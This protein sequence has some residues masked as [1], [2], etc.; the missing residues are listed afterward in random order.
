MAEKVIFYVLI[1]IIAATA[2]IGICFII[3]NRN[4]ENIIYNNEMPII[5][6]ILS[7][8][9][10]GF[11]LVRNYIPPF[12]LLL[13]AVICCAL[14]NTW[15]VFY[16]TV[17]SDSFFE[18]TVFVFR[19]RYG[20]EEIS[21]CSYRYV[22]G[23]NGGPVYT[24]NLADGKKITFGSVKNINNFFIAVSEKY[25]EIHNG[26]EIPGKDSFGE[27]EYTPPQKDENG[28]II[29]KIR[30]SGIIR[31][32]QTG[33]NEVVF[34]TGEADGHKA[35][36]RRYGLRTELVIDG[37]VYAEYENPMDYPHMLRATVD[38]HF[39]EAEYNGKAQ[40]WYLGIDRKYK[41]IT[42]DEIYN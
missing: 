31:Q 42:S 14:M 26:E 3:R 24:F 22:S 28:K 15:T 8:F 23:K 37:Y 35:V 33:G 12:H 4:N 36:Y 5:G 18:R 32:A 40:K 9:F 29:P 25:K 10:I 7:A 39:F 19:K 1:G 41:Q 17:F 21:S 6:F 20:Y 38:G 34:L 27:T 13:P 11:C 16:H 30:D 2:F